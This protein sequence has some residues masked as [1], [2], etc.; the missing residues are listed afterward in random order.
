MGRQDAPTSL[1][2]AS[3]TGPGKGCHDVVGGENAIVT[4]SCSLQCAS[5]NTFQPSS[6]DVDKN[7]PSYACVWL[8][9]C[10][11]AQPVK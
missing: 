2:T 11:I 8:P 1:V 5:D 4:V 10:G 6:I 3:C 7:A 9:V